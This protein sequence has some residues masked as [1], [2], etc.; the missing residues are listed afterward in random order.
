[1]REVIEIFGTE[2]KVSKDGKKYKITH[3]LV[4]DGSECELFGDDI[5]QGDLV[6]VFWHFNKVKARK[7]PIDSNHAT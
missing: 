7:K 2:D 5:K 6:E 4:D 1:M 3:L